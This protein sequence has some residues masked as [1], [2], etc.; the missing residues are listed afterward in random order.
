[1]ET[2]GCTLAVDGVALFPDAPTTR[3][4]RHVRELTEAKKKG[5][6]AALLILIFRPDA[7]IFVPKADTDP[8]FARAFF[9]ARERGVKI[10][11]LVFEYKNGTIYYLHE[12]PVG[13]PK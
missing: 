11:P 9:A 12:I 8:D 3:G 7:E 5:D 2:K 1:V 13:L 6:S 4:T 10:F